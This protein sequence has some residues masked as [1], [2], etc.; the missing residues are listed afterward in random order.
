MNKRDNPVQLRTA[1]RMPEH[2]GQVLQQHGEISL[3]MAKLYNFRPKNYGMSGTTDHAPLTMIQVLNAHKNCKPITY[4]SHHF[5]HNQDEYNPLQTFKETPHTW[6]INHPTKLI[7]KHPTKLI[8]T[9][10][11]KSCRKRHL[12][13]ST[14]RRPFIFQRRKGFF[15]QWHGWC[16]RDENTTANQMKVHR[17]NIVVVVFYSQWSHGWQLQRLLFSWAIDTAAI[18]EIN[19]IWARSHTTITLAPNQRSRG[20]RQITSYGNVTAFSSWPP[21]QQRHHPNLH[22]LQFNTNNNQRKG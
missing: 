4:A 6:L 1:T 7:I 12:F 14:P 21:L 10:K 17:W 8:M 3:P 2:L 16:R 5:I 13:P 15:T 18:R 19:T 20:R 22:G 11:I 9:Q